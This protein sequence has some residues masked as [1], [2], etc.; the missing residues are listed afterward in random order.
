MSPFPVPD[1]IL[2]V[3]IGTSSARAMV[4]TAAGD[5]LARARVEYGTIR[6]CPGFEEQDPDLVRA[7]VYRAIAL[8]L[9]DP[10]AEPA[11]IGAIAFSSQLYGIIAVDAAD[12][13][14]TRNILWS[15]GRAE[16]QAEA[17][18]ASLGP[19]GLYPVTGCPT[20]AIFPIAKLAWLRDAA[21]EIH[22]DAARF[23]SIKEWVTEPL[24][25][26]RV[27]DHS[28]ASATGLF[29]IRRRTWHGPALDLVGL[30]PARL[31]TPVSGLAPFALVPGGPLD[32]LGLPSDVKVFLGAGDGPLANLGSGASRNGAINI[33]LGTSGAA[34]CVTDTPITDDA[35]SLW[36]FCLTEDLWAYG[37]ILTNAGNAFAW[38]A[39]LLAPT[40]L[41]RDAGFALLDE[42]AAAVPPGSAGLHVLPYLRRARSPTW[43]GRLTGVC[44]GLG[45]DHGLGH[46]GRALYEAIAYDLASIIALMDGHVATEP[47]VVLTGGLARAPLVAQLLADVLGRPVRTPVEGE[48]SIAG[49][50]ILGALGLGLVDRPAFATTAATEAEH[51]PEPAMAELYRSLHR[52]HVRLVDAVRAISRA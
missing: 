5:V 40:G 10:A 45:P 42:L 21:P 49:A 27:V 20:S 44:W 52:E 15:D 48:G 19:L 30:D 14:L 43:D 47:T 51:H 28:M 2:A 37:G 24:I 18:K 13:P 35:A 8:C 25:G 32:G 29:D 11:R 31:S 12:R 34:R 22:A 38:L 7:E 9:S 46:L 33:D 36:C 6:P 17:M 3:D 41:S 16:A 4:F 50:A 1:R 39:E 23:V 26:E